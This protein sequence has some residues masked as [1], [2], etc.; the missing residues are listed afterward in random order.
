[1][2]TLPLDFSK[3]LIFGNVKET[4]KAAGAGRG[5]DTYMVHPSKLRF[6]DGFNPRTERPAYKEHLERLVMSMLANGFYQDKPIAGFVA[7]EG[8]EQI[9]YVV[10]GHTRTRAVLEAIK[11]GSDIEAV[12]VV[13]KPRGT[14]MED[15]HYATINT[16]EGLAL[17]PYEMGVK[18]K[19]LVDCGAKV[20][21][22]AKRI[23]RT[24][25]YVNDLLDLVA[26]PKVIRDMVI[27]GKVSATEANKQLK[28][29]GPKA[30]VKL[31]EALKAAELDA[32]A[33]GKKTVKV[34]GKHVGAKPGA[35][36]K[37]TL[38]LKGT[39]MLRHKVGAKELVVVLD[40]PLDVEVLKGDTV[41]LV[42]TAAD[43]L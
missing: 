13:I 27:D 22:I 11:R 33:K 3:E 12:P 34:T 25:P 26:A 32:A 38:K 19:H 37:A 28:A 8:D 20:E 43:D 36:T 1:M 41:R 30:V 42:V 24:V 5:Q 9:I 35:A 4:M 10:D 21:A 2:S 29:H 23:N 16:A 31:T 15:L 40:E 18:C 7:N 17:T 6:M 14:S 39:I